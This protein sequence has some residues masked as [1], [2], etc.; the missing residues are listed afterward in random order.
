VFQEGEESKCDHIKELNAT[1]KI[2][3]EGGRNLVP[4]LWRKHCSVLCTA[5][6]QA[7]E[8]RGTWEPYNWTTWYLGWRDLGT[9]TTG[10]CGTQVGGTWEP[11][12]VVPTWLKHSGQHGARV[13]GQSCP[14]ENRE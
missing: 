10:L 6:N 5:S 4:F 7:L 3:K 14:E 11:D 1:M 8:V 2:R 9:G 13:R 12:Y